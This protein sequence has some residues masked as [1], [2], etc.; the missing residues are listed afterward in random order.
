MAD[1]VTQ[2]IT[3]GADVAPVY[4]LWA[5]FANFP[6]FMKYVETV[7]MTG[8]GRSHWVV[9]GPLGKNVE[10][11]AETTMMEPNQR[12][13]WSTKDNSAVTTSGEIVFQS[14]GT[15]QTKVSVTMRYVPPAGVAGQ[16]VADLF[17]NPQKRLEED[18]R[19]FKEY[20]EGGG[21]G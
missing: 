14:L 4:T 1:Q 13:A 17:S 19:N 20:A 21:R 18:L 12:I 8:V 16:I 15:G 7:T 6:H 9:K 5:N 10:W 11:D 3:V 2:S